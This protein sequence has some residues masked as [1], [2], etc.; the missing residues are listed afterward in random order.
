M[1]RPVDPTGRE[2]VV[3]KLLG[4]GLH[5]AGDRHNPVGVSPSTAH[6]HLGHIYRKL[7]VCDRMQAV[8]LITRNLG[9][10]SALSRI[11]AVMPAW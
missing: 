9:L 8:V 7:D 2:L 3:L 11:A 1:A 5:R 4:Q 6:T 10:L